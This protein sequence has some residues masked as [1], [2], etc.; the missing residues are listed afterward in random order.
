[1]TIEAGLPLQ[2]KA[3]FTVEECKRFVEQYRQFCQ[4]DN[5]LSYQNPAD[6]ARKDFKECFWQ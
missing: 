3:V 2:P 5:D 6:E 1:V 4:E